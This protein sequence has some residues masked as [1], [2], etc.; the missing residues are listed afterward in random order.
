MIARIGD[1]PPG[2]G[3]HDRPE[4]RWQAS[5]HPDSEGSAYIPRGVVEAVEH[6]NSQPDLLERATKA[7]Y[8]LTWWTNEARATAAAA[9]AVR[10]RATRAS[11]KAL[12]AA[13]VRH[14]AALDA[15]AE[16]LLVAAQREAAARSYPDQRKLMRQ[17]DLA[18]NPQ[19]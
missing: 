3:T 16:D 13:D 19:R 12:A 15:Y 5:P 18:T 7:A 8:L 14:V 11:W 1:E 9:D 10:D 2:D 4:S 17:R 6:A